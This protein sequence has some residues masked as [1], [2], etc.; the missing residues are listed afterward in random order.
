VTQLFLAGA[1]PWSK[2]VFTTYALSLTFFETVV[3]DALIRARARDT[4][5]LSDVEGVRSSLGEKGVRGAG[6]DY[7]L[8][9][10]AVDGGVFHPKI[11]AFLGEDDAFLS[12]GSGNLTFGGWAGNLEMVEHL[13]PSFAASAFGD[14]ANLF[15]Q[16]AQHPRVRHQ[17]A[18]R[19]AMLAEDLV[20][21]SSGRTDRG[22]LRVLHGLTEGIGTQLADWAAEF[23]GATRLV[24]ASPYFDDGSG[25]EAFGRQLG[26]DEIHVHHH[27]SAAIGTAPTWPRRSGLPVRAVSL[28]CMADDRRPLHAK[29]Y[30]IVCRKGSLVVSG[31]ANA[32]AR[33]LGDNGNVEAA[34][35][36]LR[37]KASALWGW[38]PADAPEAVDTIA[39]D[40]ES[41]EPSVGV[42]RA[43]L[44]GATLRGWVLTPRMSGS[45]VVEQLT[46]LGPEVLGRVTIDESGTFHLEAPDLETKAWSAGRL[47]LR[48]STKTDI[49]EGYASSSAASTVARRIGSLAPRLFAF[50]GGSDTPDDVVALLDWIFA[51]PD[52]LPGLVK[53][54]DFGPKRADPADDVMIP[55]GDLTW[56]PPTSPGGATLVDDAKVMARL[57]DQLRRALRGKKGVYEGPVID[58]LGEDADDKEIARAERLQRRHEEAFVQSEELTV[59]FFEWALEPEK[60][61]AWGLLALELLNHMGQRLDWPAELVANWLARIASALRPES[62]KAEDRNMVAASLLALVGPVRPANVRAHLHRLRLPLDGPAP[63]PED[64]PL[65]A[66]AGGADIASAWSAIQAERSIEEIVADFVRVLKNPTPADVLR[67]ETSPLKNLS[68]E[69]WPILYGGL[70]NARLRSQIYFGKRHQ[71]ICPKC[72]GALPAADAE[73]FRMRLVATARN[74][75]HGVIIFGGDEG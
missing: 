11:S 65:Y 8:E 51:E 2:V 17:A 50:L 56:T 13:H 33:A 4:F 12:V 3:M 68:G 61:P 18:D 70:T 16:L 39:E 9:P 7:Q 53:S 69:Q 55:V 67:L 23:G 59:E 62:L 60:A 24:V 49:A 57:V 48:V 30:E 46:S 44:D 64:A 5:I 10:I 29:A 22:D 20:R 52:R 42:L 38:Q 63:D 34:V 58:D 14:V 45:A 25:L 43:Q 28:D 47:V 71:K 35:L 15:E 1:A 19:C 74:C 27:H 36:R 66:R 31:S 72:Y 21:A 26:V 54:S 37:P 75:G 32:S 73:A 6:R 40:A 41:D